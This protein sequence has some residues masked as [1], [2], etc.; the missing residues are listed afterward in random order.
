[1]RYSLIDMLR[2]ADENGYAVPAF[3]YSDIWELRAILEAAR[4]L[5]APVICATN[6]QVSAVHSISLLG[7]A[8]K[9]VMER[10]NTPVINHLDHSKSMDAC[11]EAIDCGYASVMFD[12]SALPLEDNIAQTRRVADYARG[13][14]V[15]VEGEVG[16]IRG[17]N[18]EGTYTGEDFLVLVEDAVRMAEDS[19]CDSLAIG[20]G[21]A[22][23][24]YKGKPQLNFERLRQ[25]NGAVKLPLVLH[26]GTGIPEEDIREA[27]RRG[28]NKVNVGTQLHFAYLQAMMIQAEKLEGATNIVDAMLPV[29]EAVKVPVTE[30]IR[31]CM[32]DGKA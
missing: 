31:V 4:A 30:W 1:M 17:S 10:A 21:N 7:A 32:A 19:G 20:I 6:S 18:V 3:N 16:R 5:R 15:C 11:F 14:G 23:G 28:I 2:E 27:I 29:V 22:H 12:G 13:K 26:G 8:G 25:V 9:T 24:F